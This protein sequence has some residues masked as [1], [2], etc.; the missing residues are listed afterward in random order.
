M[1][2]EIPNIIVNVAFGACFGALVGLQM[3]IGPR[4]RRP[5]GLAPRRTGQ[6]LAAYL[7]EQ[8]IRSADEAKREVDLSPSMK[9]MAASLWG[10][11]AVMVG[12]LWLSPIEMRWWWFV[13]AI[14]AVAMATMLINRTARERF[15]A[16]RARS[17]KTAV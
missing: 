16:R 5:Q 13:A 2:T 3:L 11:L 8:A 4:T 10:L 1:M 7:K 6:S 17:G 12:T 15:L 9:L 14:F